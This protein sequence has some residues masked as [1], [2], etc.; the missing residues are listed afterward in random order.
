MTPLATTGCDT[1]MHTNTY[2]SHAWQCKQIKSN[3]VLSC[4]PVQGGGVA[5]LKSCSP[6]RNGC[7]HLTASG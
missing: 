7:K 1:P 5:G 4:D 3:T 6:P 2:V